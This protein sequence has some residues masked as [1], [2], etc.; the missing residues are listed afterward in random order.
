ML[1]MKFNWELMIFIDIFMTQRA[2]LT[3]VQRTTCRIARLH[4][5]KATTIEAFLAFVRKKN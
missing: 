1:G 5:W 2:F 3:L 4:A